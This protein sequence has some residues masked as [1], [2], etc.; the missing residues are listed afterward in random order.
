MSS[1]PTRSIY[2][3]G[4]SNHAL[5]T[6]L[7]LLKSHEIEVL[8]D[9]RS[10]PYAKYAT[11]FSGRDLK[12]AVTEAGIRYLFLGNEL[13]GRPQGDEYYDPEG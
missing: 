12:A 8:V 13:G 5:D 10:Q 11:H 1:T 3:I 2:T 9:I 6:F 4:H 7:D